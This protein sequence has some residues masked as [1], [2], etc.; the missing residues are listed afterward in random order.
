MKDRVPTPAFWRISP[1]VALVAALGL[2]A[3][4]VL[5]VIQGERSYEAQKAN[6]ANV[7][8][9][10]LAS[11][12]SAALFFGD[13]EAAQGYVNA[14]N[15][16][17]EIQSVTLYDSAGSLFVK[18]SRERGSP[19]ASAPPTGTRVERSALM[20]AAPVLQHSSQVGSV[21]LQIS[22]ESITDRLLRYGVIVLL[23]MMA[24]LVVAVLGVAQRALTN[25]NSELADRA[26]ELET[27]IKEREKAES[28]LRQAQK[29]EAIGQLTGG[30]AHDFNNLLTVVIG[31]LDIV[32]GKLNDPK[33]ISRLARAAVTA[34]ERGAR[35]I[36]QLLMFARRQPMHPENVSVNRLIADFETVL[37]KGTSA[38]ATLATRLDPELASTRIDRTQFEAAILNLVV[39][40]RE[41]IS[42]T[43][44]I[45][46][47]TRNVE[48]DVEAL[49]QQ[50]D[51]P[52]G[53]YVLIEVSDNGRGIPDDELA[54]VFDPFF[55]TKEVGKGSGLGLSQ[56]YGFAKESGGFVTVRSKIG[57]G[58][59][60]SIYL[61]QSAEHEQA[62]QPEAYA[63]PARLRAENATV[64]VVEDEPIVLEMAVES[65]RQLGYEVLTAESGTQAL[66]ILKTDKPIDILFSDV[67]MPGELNGAQLAAAAA[68]VRPDMK[69]LL[70]SGYTASVLKEEHGLDSMPLVLEKP[71]R[72]GDLAR[73]FELLTESRVPL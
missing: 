23:V 64:L 48:L 61:P 43:G 47:E 68:R 6:E 9:R 14:L 40:A 37:R 15:A 16:N 50:P 19:P 13:R 12:V 55:T 2:L 25:A 72:P 39:N 24:S 52:P 7:Q 33:E 32:Q 34:A 42:G 28:A 71:Y 4:G 63:E 41:A 3:A 67:V 10:I 22:I 46:I 66:E 17:P 56:V 70:T 54:L 21:A 8:A 11:T 26:S 58:T 20:V 45:R 30:V 53:H 69:V 65:L 5:V 44:Q 29:M 60:V 57:T 59:T 35:L 27:Q 1:A 18:Y 38:N 62:A 31:N 49:T 51:V 73:R 36:K